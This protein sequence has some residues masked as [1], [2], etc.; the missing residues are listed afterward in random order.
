MVKEMNRNYMTHDEFRMKRREWDAKLKKKALMQSLVNRRCELRFN[1][2]ILAKK[3]NTSQ[4]Q[5]S[6][7]EQNIQN[8]SIEKIIELCQALDLELSIKT[9]DEQRVVFHSS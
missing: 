4:K 6:H 2:T 1:Q 3:A 9:K 5:I 8:P 7:Y